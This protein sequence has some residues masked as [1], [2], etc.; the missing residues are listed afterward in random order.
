MPN[1][2][3]IDDDELCVVLAN[4]TS[5]TLQRKPMEL[6]NKRRLEKKLTFRTLTL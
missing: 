6:Q 4:L 5:L 1:L 3:T 2:F